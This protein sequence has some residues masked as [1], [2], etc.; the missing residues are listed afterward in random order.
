MALWAMHNEKG[1]LYSLV[2]SIT[3]VVRP[4]HCDK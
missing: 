3:G 2:L 4:S 1:V